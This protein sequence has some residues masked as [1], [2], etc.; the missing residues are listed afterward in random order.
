MRVAFRRTATQKTTAIDDP[1]MRSSLKRETC[2]FICRYTLSMMF[3]SCNIIYNIY[4]L[5]IYIHFCIRCDLSSMWVSSNSWSW[6]C[7]TSCPMLPS[8]CAG[9][10]S[11]ARGATLQWGAALPGAIWN[12]SW[13]LWFSGEVEKNSIKAKKSLG[14][15]LNNL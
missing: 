5:C 6:P 11:A 3:F 7:V 2:S 15:F 1:H 8:D 10:L 14:Y 13:W 12:L 4:I 9:V